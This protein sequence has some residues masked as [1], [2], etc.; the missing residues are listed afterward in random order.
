MEESLRTRMWLS[1]DGDTPDDDVFRLI[2]T[3]TDQENG[4]LVEPT[5]SGPGR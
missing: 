2:E 1:V 4:M 3:L 5:G